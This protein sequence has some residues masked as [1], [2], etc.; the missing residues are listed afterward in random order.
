MALQELKFGDR[1]S[2]EKAYC[3]PGEDH[4]DYNFPQ[5]SPRM[6]S[7]GLGGDDYLEIPTYIRRGI[8]LSC[9]AK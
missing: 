8:S 6:E 5:G 1:S 3:K 7:V 4:E 9:G 2:W